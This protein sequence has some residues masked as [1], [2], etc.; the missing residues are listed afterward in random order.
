M[1][2]VDGLHKLFDGKEI[3]RGVS[4]EIGKGEVIALIGGSGSGK[5][6]LLKHVVG[7]MKP[8]RGRVIVDGEDIGMLG[9]RGLRALRDRLGFLF[10]GGALFDSLTVLENVAFPLKEK[11]SMSDEMVRK[12]A[13]EELEHVGL[14]GSEH[15]YLSQ[16][17]GGMVKRAAIARAL[18]MEPEIM[19]F[20]EPTTGLDPQV[21]HLIW[22]KI[23][24]L[25]REGVTILLTTHYMEEAFQ[26]CN[27]LIIMNNSEK[28]LEGK[29][30][31]LI[32][33]NIEKFVIEI[34]S[35]EY[36][37]SKMIQNIQINK[38]LRLEKSDGRIL[39]YS[40]QID[41]L[42]ELSQNYR[43]GEY[44][45]RQSNLEDLFLKVTGRTLDE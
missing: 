3:L 20:D 15:K 29:P 14:S 6:V 17:S 8:D 38:K 25:K 35:L 45:L 12:K 42:K 9:T 5:S 2:K 23:R 36:L 16:I 24:M 37:S 19:L 39:I 1:I 30:G 31:Q 11:T 40:D 26:L 18:V 27:N 10:Q 32:K 28:I 7:L 34:F 41:Q 4:L 21:R 13:L 33:D 44:Y 43:A 22:D